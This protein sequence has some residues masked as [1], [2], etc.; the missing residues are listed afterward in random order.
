MSPWSML[1]K[2]RKFWLV[3]LDVLIS[4]LTYFVTKYAAPTLAEDIHWLILSW[5]PVFA[6]IIGAI[7]YEDRGNVIAGY[8]PATRKYTNPYGCDC[9]PADGE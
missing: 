2:S 7:A 3:M 9:D 6:L 4:T 1:L 8:N 5:Q